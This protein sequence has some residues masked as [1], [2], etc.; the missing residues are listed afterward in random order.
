MEERMSTKQSPEVVLEVVRDPKTRSGA[1][2][3]KGTR[4]AI[5]DIVGY[6]Q[7]YEGDLSRIAAEALPHLSLAEVEAAMAWY[8]EHREEVDRRLRDR[9]A[10]VTGPGVKKWKLPPGA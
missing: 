10:P 6:A 9:L 4:T 3:L 5:H 8:E 2:I 7:L 1:P